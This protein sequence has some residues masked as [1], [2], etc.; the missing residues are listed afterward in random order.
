M[1]GIEGKRARR[2]RVASHCTRW[3]EVSIS[4]LRLLYPVPAGQMRAQLALYLLHVT[5]DCPWRTD[6]SLFLTIIYRLETL[7]ILP[8]R[9]TLQ[10]APSLWLRQSFTQCFTV[11]RFTL[12]PSSL[13]SELRFDL[14]RLAAHSE[15]KIKKVAKKIFFRLRKFFFEIR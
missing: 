1:I 2:L 6:T 14:G 3:T 8:T 15:K 11:S 12:S 13:G 5:A 7:I 9:S 10:P 4:H